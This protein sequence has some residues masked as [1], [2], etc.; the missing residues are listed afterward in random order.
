M[1][2]LYPDCSADA[3]R[4]MDP[5]TR[6]GVAAAPRKRKKKRKKKSKH[7]PLP[8]DPL[9]CITK[10]RN[11]RPPLLAIRLVSSS[12]GIN[13]STLQNGIRIGRRSHLAPTQPN[14]AQL[15]PGLIKHYETTARCCMRDAAMHACRVDGDVC[16]GGQVS[17]SDCC[18]PWS[19]RLP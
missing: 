14:P 1:T 7:G 18:V 17:G 10:V 13:E 9:L 3:R 4:G 16:L 11:S 8:A 15:G 6:R 12:L 2:T 19:F 5:K